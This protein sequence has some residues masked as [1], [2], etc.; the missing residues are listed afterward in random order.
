MLFNHFLL[1]FFNFFLFKKKLA[2]LCLSTLMSVVSVPLIIMLA[3]WL[4]QLV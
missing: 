2:C 3:S 1:P 4:K